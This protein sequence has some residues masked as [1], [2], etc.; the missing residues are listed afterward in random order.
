MFLIETPHTVSPA[1]Q[2]KFCFSMQILI[3]L[4]R[5]PEFHPKL[6]TLGMP[7]IQARNVPYRS[8]HKV[9]PV[10]QVHFAANCSWLRRSSAFFQRDANISE[11]SKSKTAK[12]CFLHACPKPSAKDFCMTYE[13]F[14]YTRVGYGRDGSTTSGRRRGD[15]IMISGISTG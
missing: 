7:P 13:K 9:S 4:G 2:D 8:P 12:S 15:H 5:L 14:G 10:T 6:N 1:T 11:N 3:F